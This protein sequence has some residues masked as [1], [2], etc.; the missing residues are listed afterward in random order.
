VKK[1]SPGYKEGRGHPAT[2]E[3]AMVVGCGRVDEL[4]PTSRS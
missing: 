2:D 3:E 4:I 1:L